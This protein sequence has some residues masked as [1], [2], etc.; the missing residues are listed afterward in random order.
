MYNKEEV[1]SFLRSHYPNEDTEAICRQLGLSK[2]T[3]WTLATRNK[4][5]KSD[6]YLKMLHDQLM[7]AK[8]KKYLASIPEVSLEQL[9]QNIIVGSILGDGS[10][11]YSPRSRNAYYRE[12]FS[13]KQKG[14]REWKLNNIHSFSFRIEN[15]CHLKSPSHP[16]FTELYKQFY[17]DSCK[18]ITEENIKLLNHPIGLAC[19][20]M[21]DGTLMINVSKSKT[22]FHIFP[23]IGITTLCFYKTECEILAKHIMEL[24]GIQFYLCSHP[25]GKGW[26][27]K[28]SRLKE[29]NKFF[30]LILPYCEE[31]RC[32]RYKWDIASRLKQKR[33]EL[34]A[35]LCK[36]YKVNISSIENI[37][38][39]YSPEQ[40]NMILQMKKSGKTYQEIANAIDRTY[41]GISYKLSQMRKQGKI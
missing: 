30:D 34:V 6:E 31:V 27:L 2:S 39:Y 1:L 23:T 15:G 10:L 11:T 25:H 8:E 18:T 36:E 7:K 38:D 19:L 3:I 40:E 21:D 17:I 5:H 22:T 9:E 37:S 14:Y 4:I 26:T 12:H 29:I 33:Q 32:L 20:Y 28:L 24:F 16:V 41:S 13:L 35:K